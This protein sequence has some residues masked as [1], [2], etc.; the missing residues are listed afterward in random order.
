MKIALACQSLLLEKALKLFLHPHLVPLK[1]CEFVIG[2]YEAVGDKPLFW[3]GPQKSDVGFPFSKTS[4]MLA[5]EAFEANLKH[6]EHAAP[7]EVKTETQSF[8]LLEEQ[9][10]SITKRYHAELVFAIKAHYET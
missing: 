8:A 9:L 1:Q 2:D 5:L 7:S 4:L 3:V 6:D 10:E